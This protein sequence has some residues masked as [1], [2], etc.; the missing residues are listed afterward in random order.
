[1]KPFIFWGGTDVDSR[2]YGEEH[3]PQAQ[4]PDEVRDRAEKS[5]YEQHRDRGLPMIGI[6][7]G[8][9]FLCVMNG[10]RLW[11][12]TRDHGTSHSLVTNKGETI[13]KAC[14]GHHQVMDPT[15]TDHELIAW[16]PFPTEIDTISSGIVTLER[17]PEVVWFP[18]TKCLAIQPHPEW[19]EK[20]TP[21][22][23]WVDALV[24]EKFGFPNFLRSV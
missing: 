17:S 13:P 19:Q 3:H 2:L 18:K 6:C 24:E 15:K 5:L 20:D 8:A 21:F 11:Q 10:G 9:Q 16:A 14:A 4:W 1:M 7:R 22:Y 12:H 23:N